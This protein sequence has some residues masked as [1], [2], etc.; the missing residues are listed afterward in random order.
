MR[1]H[2]VLKNLK[3]NTFGGDIYNGKVTLKEAG[4]NQSSLLVEI[5]NFKKKTGPQNTEKKQEKRDILKDL[6]ALFE[7]R[8]RVLDAF[9][10]KISPIKIEG[11]DFLDKA[12]DHTNLKI[13]TPK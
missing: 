1:I 13:L 5:M 4:E 6:Y 11:I 9:E 12:S 10:S 8:K 7:G 3:I 2:I